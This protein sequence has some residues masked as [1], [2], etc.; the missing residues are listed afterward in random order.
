MFPLREA[1]HEP[2]PLHLPSEN[3]QTSQLFYC[4]WCTAFPLFCPGQHLLVGRSRWLPVGTMVTHR[5]RT[6]A[7]RAILGG[8]QHPHFG[9]EAKGTRNLFRDRFLSASPYRSC[10]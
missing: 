5:R 10:D 3:P 9:R 4:S 7:M 1:W 2:S 6:T 8:G